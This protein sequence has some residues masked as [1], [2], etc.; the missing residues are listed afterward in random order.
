MKLQKFTL[1][2]ALIFSIS[3]YADDPIH[4]PRANTFAPLTSKDDGNYA[5]IDGFS[6]PW[7]GGPD[8]GH[9]HKEFKFVKLVFTESN[10]TKDMYLF[11]AC[12]YTIDGILVRIEPIDGP[13]VEAM[14]RLPED[15]HLYSKQGS[16]MVCTANELNCEIGWGV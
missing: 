6:T 10:R 14:F 13:M 5:S 12:Y 11:D 1:F 7:V 4:C 16:Q 3:A 15:E 8:D 2:L 9:S